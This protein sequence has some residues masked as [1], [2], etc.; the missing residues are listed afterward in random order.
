MFGKLKEVK[1]IKEM[2]VLKSL[3]VKAGAYLELKQISMTE[4]FC[5]N[6]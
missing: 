2:K 5:E 1:C 4:R 3:L 6:S